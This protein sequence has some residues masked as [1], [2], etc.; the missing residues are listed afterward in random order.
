MKRRTLFTTFAVRTGSTI[1]NQL[2][3]MRKQDI[4]EV[5]G[6]IFSLYWQTALDGKTWCRV[7][8]SDKPGNTKQWPW[9]YKTKKA[10]K[11][12]IMAK[13]KGETK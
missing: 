9:Y 11:I 5:G 12:D 10:A 2:P 1:D 6:Y 3:Q 4:I 13:M 7:K 8:Y